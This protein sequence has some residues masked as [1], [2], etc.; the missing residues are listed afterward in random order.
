MGGFYS[1]QQLFGVPD[2]P[3]N[4]TLSEEG[5]VAGASTFLVWGPKLLAAPLFD[6]RRALLPLCR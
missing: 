4:N 6:I 5:G 1:T 3:I 2:D